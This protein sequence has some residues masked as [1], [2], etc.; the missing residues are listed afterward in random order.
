MTSSKEEAEHLSKENEDLEKYV[1]ELEQNNNGLRAEIKK[2]M[3]E[4]E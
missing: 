2:I 3:T 1:D 4:K